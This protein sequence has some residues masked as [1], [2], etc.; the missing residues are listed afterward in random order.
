MGEPSKEATWILVDVS[1]SMASDIADV[2]GAVLDMLSTKIFHHKQ[3]VVGILLL[4]TEKSENALNAEMG[5]G[6]YEHITTLRNMAKVDF[7]ALRTVHDELEADSFAQP[8][9]STASRSASTCCSASCGSSSSR[10][11]CSSSRAPRRRATPTTTTSASSR[12]R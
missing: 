8:T 4:G 10:S 6:Q 5:D 11:G 9:S 12:R 2:K 3:D 7:D 1:R